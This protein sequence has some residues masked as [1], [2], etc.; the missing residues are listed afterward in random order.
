ML[1]KLRTGLGFRVA[2]VIAALAALC[3]VAPPAVMA[4]GHGNNTVHCLANANAVDHGM[5]GGPR[6]KV[7]AR[8]SGQ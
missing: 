1:Q 7:S 6:K 3:L 8:V 2:V 4:F 5:H